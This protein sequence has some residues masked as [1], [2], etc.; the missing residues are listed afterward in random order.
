VVTGQYK[1]AVR[2]NKAIPTIQL[3][4]C[5]VT[6]MKF[7]GAV[8]IFESSALLSFLHRSLR[9]GQEIFNQIRVDERPRPHFLGGLDGFL[10]RGFFQTA[11][12][13]ATLVCGNRLSP[14]GIPV[15]N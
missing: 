3:R 11:G 8:K 13:C 15:S 12:V 4:C 2:T 1:A 7:I 5:S 9:A 6:R 10:A 14:A